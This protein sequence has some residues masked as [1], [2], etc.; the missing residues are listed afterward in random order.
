[1]L[2][3]D[4]DH[5]EADALKNTITNLL[6]PA[7]DAIDRLV[8]QFDTGKGA[9]SQPAFEQMCID[10]ASEIKNLIKLDERTETYKAAVI[11]LPSES[12]SLTEQFFFDPSLS[13]SVTS[14]P[15]IVV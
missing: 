14:L 10:T 11:G 5:R 3:E 6:D 9:I 13:L 2:D 7:I 4:G 8:T 15:Q 1:M 12:P